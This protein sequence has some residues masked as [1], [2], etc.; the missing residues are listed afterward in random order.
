MDE[1]PGPDATASPTCVHR[2]TGNNVQEFWMNQIV[3]G[4]DSN[5]SMSLYLYLSKSHGSKS[6]GEAESMLDQL[7]QGLKKQILQ[8]YNEEPEL[9]VE[10][11]ADG[12]PPRY[13]LGM[14]GEGWKMISK[15]HLRSWIRV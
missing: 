11:P 1:E 7:F 3:I 6:M 14:S 4:D 9:P 2:T 13:V 10:P 15:E 8:A 12:A 5:P